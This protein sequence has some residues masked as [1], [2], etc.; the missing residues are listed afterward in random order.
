MLLGGVKVLNVKEIISEDYVTI[1]KVVSSIWKEYHAV[2][3]DFFLV[4]TKTNL[5][6]EGGSQMK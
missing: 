5:S 3:V 1:P 2:L 4:F 6:H